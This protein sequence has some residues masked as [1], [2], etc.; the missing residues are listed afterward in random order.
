MLRNIIRWL[1][2]TCAGAIRPKNVFSDT[3]TWRNFYKRE[4]NPS[5]DPTRLKILGYFSLIFWRF[6]ISGPG[7][8]YV[9]SGGPRTGMVPKFAKTHLKIAL[10]PQPD[11]VGGP[12]GTWNLRKEA[13]GND[14]GCFHD[15]RSTL[16]LPTR[17]VT[18]FSEFFLDLLL[19]SPTW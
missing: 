11:G 16:G 2:R 8:R 4:R 5:L 12:A 3:K 1:S 13:I 14:L 19:G 17:L 10:S 18:C 15:P 9:R 6:P 7:Y